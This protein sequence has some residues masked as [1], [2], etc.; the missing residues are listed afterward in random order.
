MLWQI[1]LN[2]FVKPDRP[3]ADYRSDITGVTAKDLEGANCSLA[4]VQVFTWGVLVMRLA[5]NCSLPEVAFL[6]F[7][8]ILDENIVSW[9]DLG[10]PQLK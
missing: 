2:E 7:A 10:G 4:D 8:E 1:K 3:V 5:F 6:I 9:K